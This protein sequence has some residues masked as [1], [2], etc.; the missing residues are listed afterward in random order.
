MPLDSMS[1]YFSFASALD[2]LNIFSSDPEFIF[3][4]NN[5]NLEFFND[6][7]LFHYFSKNEI[8]VLHD[9]N[10]DQE[11]FNI[12]PSSLLTNLSE[13]TYEKNDSLKL[14]KFFPD[15]TTHEILTHL[16]I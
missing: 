9:I 13:I 2:F 4:S 7:F 6:N 16:E 5:V 14:I 11:F 3:T 1:D 8:P 10:L 15:Y 12:I